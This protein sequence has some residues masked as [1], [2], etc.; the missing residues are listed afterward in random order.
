MDRPLLFAL[1]PWTAACLIVL[2]SNPEFGRLDP[3]FR[4]PD[5]RYQFIKQRKMTFF[6]FNEIRKQLLFFR[7]CCLFQEIGIEINALLFFFQSDLVK[8]QLCGRFVDLAFKVLHILEQILDFCI[9]I[10]ARQFINALIRL[11]F[12]DLGMDPLFLR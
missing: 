5:H 6:L 9:G 4:M 12:K 8:L 3:F 7:I 10:A 1:I 2:F 11:I